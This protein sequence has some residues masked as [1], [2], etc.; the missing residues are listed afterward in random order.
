[1]NKEE[2]KVGSLVR[3]VRGFDRIAVNEDFIKK[4]GVGIVIGG[5]PNQRTVFWTGNCQSQRHYHDTNLEL[6]P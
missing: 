6:I 4:L 1:M 3:R 5:Q 2:I